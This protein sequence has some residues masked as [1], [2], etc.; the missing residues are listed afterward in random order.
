MKRFS[1]ITLVAVLII[2]GEPFT[3]EAAPS[4][5]QM[6]DRVFGSDGRGGDAARFRALRAKIDEETRNGQVQAAAADRAQAA[7]LAASILANAKVMQNKRC[8]P[9]VI[10]AGSSS[11]GRTTH[12]IPSAPPL[13]SP[14]GPVV[15]TM[16]SVHGC[17]GFD[18]TWET[19]T[20]PLRIHNG[21]GLLGSTWFSGDV[22][23][24]V[25]R[26]GWADPPPGGHG[27]FVFTLAQ[28]GDSIS[29]IL[30]NMVSNTSGSWT[31]PCI[32]PP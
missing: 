3:A 25:Y 2:S 4:C 21:A 9:R 18:G 26:G 19:A 16:R 17:V 30:K 24:N 23:G 8:T 14:N 7:R 12:S 5:T 1:I 20:G 6:N 32:G 27:T 11:A 28:D 29:A 10:A 31:A 13:G 22:N 15:M